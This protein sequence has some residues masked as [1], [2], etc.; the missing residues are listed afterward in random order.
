MLF[1]EEAIGWMHAT[2]T[3]GNQKLSKYFVFNNLSIIN[4]SNQIYLDS[5][6]VTLVLK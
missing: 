6:K 1:S 4:N 2:L 5:F 3:F